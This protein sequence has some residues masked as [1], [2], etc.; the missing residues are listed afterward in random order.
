MEDCTHENQELRRL[1]INGSSPQYR[2]QC[3]ICGKKGPALG[4]AK[5]TEDQKQNAP[6]ID[7]TLADRYWKAKRP[8]LDAQQEQRQAEW[9]TE[10]LAYL[11]TPQWQ[12]KRRKVLERDNYLCQSCMEAPATQVHHLSY[13]HLGDEPL[14]ELVAVCTPCHERITAMDRRRYAYMPRVSSIN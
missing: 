11:R 5:L 9:W 2:M 1:D 12:S 14:F 8:Q 3:L 4:H 10:Y 13:E 6:A 7:E